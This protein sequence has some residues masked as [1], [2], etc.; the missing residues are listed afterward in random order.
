MR[1]CRCKFPQGISLS[2][3]PLFDDDYLNQLF[4]YGLQ[5]GGFS[6]SVISFA[7]IS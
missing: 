1:F 5:N 6:N 4:Y 7:S 3:L 2:S